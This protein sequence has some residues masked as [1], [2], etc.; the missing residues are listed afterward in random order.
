MTS[1]DEY[2]LLAFEVEV[3]AKCDAEERAGRPTRRTVAGRRMREKKSIAD[4]DGRRRTRK[5][6]NAERDR[7]QLNATVRQEVKD[8]LVHAAR[9]H[10]RPMVEIIEAALTEYLAKIGGKP[11]KAGRHA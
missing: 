5:Q 6:A 4:N 1:G 8:E 2:D 3:A 10:G 7:V 11:A 9:V